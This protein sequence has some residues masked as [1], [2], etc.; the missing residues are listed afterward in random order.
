MLFFLSIEVHDLSLKV[1][2]CN[3]L[4]LATPTIH[5]LPTQ[6][7]KSIN[8][9][10]VWENRTGTLFAQYFVHIFSEHFLQNTSQGIF[11]LLKYDWFPKIEELRNSD[12]I[13]EFR[14]S[15]FRLQGPLK[16]RQPE[17]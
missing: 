11:S 15:V 13:T 16:D 10:F 12:F 5:I 9:N 4:Q 14:K 8:E 17:V 2:V 1:Q 3:Q 7:Y 6:T